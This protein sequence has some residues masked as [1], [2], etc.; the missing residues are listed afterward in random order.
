MGKFQ[1]QQKLVKL[2]VFNCSITKK[3]AHSLVFFN[4]FAYFSRNI[5]FHEHFLLTASV[6]IIVQDWYSEACLLF[7]PKNIY[8]D[9]VEVA[10]WLIFTWPMSIFYPILLGKNRTV[11]FCILPNWAIRFFSVLKDLGNTRIFP[12]SQILF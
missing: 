9:W 5:Y 6:C 4:C 12:E 3:W 7:T 8:H 10:R 1:T 2:Q 11:F